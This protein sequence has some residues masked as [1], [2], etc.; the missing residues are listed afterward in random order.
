VLVQGEVCAMTRTWKERSSRGP[1]EKEVAHSCCVCG[2]EGTR[3]LRQVETTILRL[4]TE[5]EMEGSRIW[6]PHLTSNG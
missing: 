4:S 2:L 5:L 3:R 6:L 1:G